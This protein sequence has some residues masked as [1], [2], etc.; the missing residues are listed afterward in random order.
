MLGPSCAAAGNLLNI[1]NPAGVRFGSAKVSGKTLTIK[2][3]S[4]QPGIYPALNDSYL[5]ITDVPAGAAVPAPHGG[6]TFAEAFPNGAYEL[7]DVGSIDSPYRHLFAWK[8]C[9]QVGTEGGAWENARVYCDKTK[10]TRIKIASG[11]GTDLVVVDPAI[12]VTVTSKCGGRRS[13][14]GSLGC[15]AS[16]DVCCEAPGFAGCVASPGESCDAFDPEDAS[17]LPFC[18]Q[19]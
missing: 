1:L 13:P 9:R 10:V 18:P 3:D 11:T 15:V 7:V 5:R 14:C 16:P 19:F 8:G 4:S 6:L 2:L 17:T 12:S